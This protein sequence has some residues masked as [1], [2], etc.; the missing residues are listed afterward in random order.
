MIMW[1]AYGK[2]RIKEF[3]NSMVDEVI[4]RGRYYSGPFESC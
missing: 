2:L 4:R 3:D 1:Y